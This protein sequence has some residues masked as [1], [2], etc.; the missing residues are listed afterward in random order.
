MNFTTYTDDL[1]QIIHLE[2]RGNL[3]DFTEEEKEIFLNCCNANFFFYDPYKDLFIN[4]ITEK[5]YWPKKLQ[6]YFLLSKD[7]LIEKL[8]SQNPTS[9]QVDK[10]IERLHS[11]DKTSYK[12]FWNILP[13]L[14]YFGLIIGGFLSYFIDLKLGFI[15]G[16]YLVYVSYNVFDSFHG[17]IALIEGNV[18]LSFSWQRNRYLYYFL[19]TLLLIG[20]M[21]SLYL[22]LNS[23]WIVLGVFLS[24]KYIVMNPLVQFLSS[25]HFR[26]SYIT[27]KLIEEYEK[28]N[29]INQF[30]KENPKGIKIN[31][32]R[33]YSNLICDYLEVE[34]FQIRYQTSDNLNGV[35]FL[36]VHS[37]E[38]VNK[39][40]VE[41]L[42][43]A[44]SFIDSIVLL[45]ENEKIEF[46]L[47]IIPEHS[48]SLYYVITKENG[49]GML[50]FDGT[51]SKC[52]VK[53]SHTNGQVEMYYE[54]E[55]GVKHGKMIW[56]Y[57]DGQKFYDLDYQNGFIIPKCY[58]WWN[59]DG[60]IMMKGELRK[61]DNANPDLQ[62][63][64]DPHSKFRIG[65]WE[66]FDKSGNLIKSVKYSPNGD[67]EVIFEDLNT[68]P[69]W[70]WL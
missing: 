8:S 34:D 25:A 32:Y 7:F 22:Y 29:R 13:T 28:Q 15:V 61:I 56:F 18:G 12:L 9:N 62:E 17:V 49:T 55:Y 44:E 1:Q 35:I 40:V 63:V 23:F 3:K 46:F 43:Y 60:S 41:N 27:T 33:F 19:S 70:N 51:F 21:T 50:D 58:T 31:P 66:H 68:K 11:K 39:E 52:V 54:Y 64:L 53:S 4:P 42:I 59:A 14:K 24:E 67:Y 26:G 36:C 57:D 6:K 48:G 45:H 65:I 37:K 69:S 38:P 10:A 20:W 30:I 5:T 16:L 2:K 47:D